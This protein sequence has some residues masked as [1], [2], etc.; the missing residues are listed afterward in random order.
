MKEGLANEY[1]AHNRTELATRRLRRLFS[2]VFDEAHGLKAYLERHPG[3]VEE[4]LGFF[5]SEVD[6]MNAEFGISSILDGSIF[7]N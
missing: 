1:L 7:S 5:K 2:D 6:S 4:N 3:E